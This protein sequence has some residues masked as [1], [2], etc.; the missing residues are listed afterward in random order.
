MNPRAV[1]ITLPAIVA[2]QL[3]PDSQA[4]TKSPAGAAAFNPVL[5]GVR[6]AYVI[7]GAMASNS[8]A[9]IAM[10]RERI[11]D[12]GEKKIFLM[13]GQDQQIWIRCAALD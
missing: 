6:A 2:I 4:F 1:L 3:A 9:T 7:T 8:V 13:L 11:D 5:S 10:N 12:M